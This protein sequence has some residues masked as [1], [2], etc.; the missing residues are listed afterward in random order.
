MTR[1]Q[2]N[3]KLTIWGTNRGSQVFVTDLSRSE[4]VALQSTLQEFSSVFLTAGIP[5]YGIEFT[6]E[7]KV[8]T[9]YYSAMEERGPRNGIFLAATIF[10]PHRYRL[11]DPLS[12]LQAMGEKVKEAFLDLNGRYKGGLP[13]SLEHDFAEY[14]EAKVEQEQIE[15]RDFNS[16]T[17]G[18]L[19]YIICPDD[20]SIST[21]LREPYRKEFKAHQEV[22]LIPQTYV[23]SGR[24]S[25]SIGQ[26]LELNS[27]SRQHNGYRLLHNE[28]ITGVK[29]GGKDCTQDYNT[30]YL[31]LGT[32]LEM[33]LV[34]KGYEP[35]TYPCRPLEDYLRSGLARLSGEEVHIE[36]GKLVWRKPK[37]TVCISLRPEVFRQTAR[38]EL[39]IGDISSLPMTKSWYD[40]KF[41]IELEVDLLQKDATLYLY[42]EGESKPYSYSIGALE[43]TNLV[44]KK[45]L[46]F[47]YPTPVESK[48]VS[49]SGSSANFIANSS[50]PEVNLKEFHKGH[51]PKDGFRPREHEGT[52]KAYDNS[53][54]ESSRAL[55]V[56][57]IRYWREL[58]IAVF[59]TLLIGYNLGLFLPICSFSKPSIVEENIYPSMSTS[60][61]KDTLFTG[62]DADLWYVQNT[63][64][65]NG[66]RLHKFYLKHQ[67]GFDKVAS[68]I[69]SLKRDR[70]GLDSLITKQADTIGLKNKEIERLNK[71][72]SKGPKKVIESRGSEGKSSDENR[73]EQRKKRK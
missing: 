45:C 70:D 36:E 44:A 17:R 37:K 29:I 51:E 25:P 13:P 61:P 67:D 46:T 41:L 26:S 42:K 53:V 52:N 63:F 3:V 65:S 50:K 71:K 28:L 33:R 69:D 60:T 35:I 1:E 4:Q 34:R 58:L 6:A 30:Q 73:K 59:I 64:P 14:R 2:I 5:F 15:R 18:N 8:Y 23:V 24:F 22:L 27:L 49:R 21:I 57:L 12:Y 31:G 66:N 19:A 16:D 11:L 48:A 55:F 54:K 40:G 72:L 39:Q 56:T 32:L 47:I 68:I 7:Y 20:T 43:D 9:T 38:A 62:T 10:I